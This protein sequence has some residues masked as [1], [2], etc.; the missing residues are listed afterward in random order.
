MCEPIGYVEEYVEDGKI[1][2][3]CQDF[4]KFQERL[5]A[6]EYVGRKLVRFHEISR[7]HNM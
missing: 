4:V 3:W 2:W 7:T 1:G 5:F 6:G